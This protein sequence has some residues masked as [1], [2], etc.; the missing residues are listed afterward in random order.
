V[1]CNLTPK[2]FDNS[3]VVTVQS[4]ERQAY[5]IDTDSM[6]LDKNV[7]FGESG[8]QAVNDLSNSKALYDD[9]FV[10][11]HDP[12]VLDDQRKRVF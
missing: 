8:D 11:R 2:F 10:R 6:S 5:E 4:T 12:E 7:I 9:C 3:G 1:L